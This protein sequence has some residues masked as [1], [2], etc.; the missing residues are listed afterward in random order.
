M[1]SWI[2]NPKAVYLAPAARVTGII[3]D[4]PI[5]S[6]LLLDGKAPEVPP[7]RV[8]DASQHIVLPGLINAHH[9]FYQTLTRA[10]PAALNQ[11]LFPWLKSLYPVWSGLNENMIQVSTRLAAAEL[12][13]SGCTL[14]ADHHYLFPEAVPQA[15]DVQIEAVKGMGIRV[16]LTRGSMS[17]GVEQGGLP[18]QNTVQDED[19]ILADCERVIERYHDA[20]FG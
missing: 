9:H 16:M 18:P 13:L 6:E 2:K 17:L 14:A 7:D 20:G 11:A 8:I 5:I 10:H 15:L 19:V 3:V 12:L 1:R 4:G